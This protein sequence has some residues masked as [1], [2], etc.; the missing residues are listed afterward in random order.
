[1]G[2]REDK[3]ELREKYKALR[4]EISRE[5]KALLDEQVFHAFT[6]SLSYKHSKS[7]IIYVSREDEVGT[8]AIINKAFEDNKKVA[9][10]LCVP[11]T[12]A[13]EFYEIENLS[14][15][16][17]GHYNILEPNKDK[18]EKINPFDFDIC[19]VPGVC[20]DFEG[21][22]IGFGKGYYDRFLENFKGIK[23][24]LSYSFLMQKRLPRGRF[25]KNI[26]I[27]ATEKGVRRLASV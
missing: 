7:I 14:D 25:D 27:I 1:M 9:V 17:N 6:N 8:F 4:A 22:R 13:L 12:F 19:V 11:K 24:G 21:Y 3:K 26:E 10:P 16:E 2:V 5:Q 15:L 20:F 18:C 23:A